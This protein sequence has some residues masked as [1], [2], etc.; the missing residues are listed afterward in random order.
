MNYRQRKR[1]RK[2]ERIQ[3]NIVLKINNSILC[4]AFDIS[5]GG[6]YVLTDQP[7]KPGAVIKISLLFRKEILEIQS[8][9]KYCHEGVGI[10]IMFIDL[11]NELKDKIKE[12]VNDIKQLT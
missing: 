7:F 9:V 6:M 4:N 10:G 2:Q 11:D 8:K 12:L 5:A 1:Q 3:C